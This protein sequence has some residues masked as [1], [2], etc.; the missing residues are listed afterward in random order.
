MNVVIDFEFLRGRQNKIAGK[1]VSES[2]RLKSPYAMAAHGSDENGLIVMTGT[3]RTINCSQSSRRLWRILHTSTATG[4][5]NAN[6]LTCWA[7]QITTCEILI[8]RI[9]RRQLRN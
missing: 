6:C 4:L 3:Y 5:Q 9:P 8:A 7:F 2:F 1:N